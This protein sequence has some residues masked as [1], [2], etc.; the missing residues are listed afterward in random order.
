MCVPPQPGFYKAEPGNGVCTKCPAGQIA[1]DA[2][3]TS[4]I[5]CRPQDGIVNPDRTQCQ[6]ELALRCVFL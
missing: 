5:T 3:S 1:Q 6:R 4:C 2:A